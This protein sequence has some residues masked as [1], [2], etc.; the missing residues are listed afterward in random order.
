MKEFKE[1]DIPGLKE[2]GKRGAVAARNLKNELK[3][4]IDKYGWLKRGRER[5]KEAEAFKK[6]KEENDIIME[7]DLKMI[8]RL[9]HKGPEYA[10]LKKLMN[11][12]LMKDFIH[13]IW[14]SGFLRGI[15]RA[16]EEFDK[17]KKC[18]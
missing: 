1:N 5:M 16:M 3:L 6:F 14:V 9:C 13:A 17:Q 10:L 2:A 18:K 4:L 15:K 11:T 12:S 7:R 8:I